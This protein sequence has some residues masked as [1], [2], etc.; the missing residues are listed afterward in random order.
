[1]LELPHGTV[2]LLFSDVEGSTALLSRLGPLYADALDGHRKIMRAAWAA[3]GGSEL[4]TEGD[5]FFVVFTAASHAIAAAVEAQQRL[6]GHSWPEGVGLRVRIGIHTGAPQVHDG[7]YIGMD[8][9]RAARIAAA[10]H[11]GQV[12]VSEVTARLL[13]GADSGLEVE[14]TDLGMH[15]LRDLPQPERLYQVGVAGRQER[16]PP[17]KSLG[18]SSRLPRRPTRL[19]GRAGELRSIRSA[20]DDP[21]ARLLTLTGPGGSGKTRLA[22]EAAQD[23][24]ESFGDGVFFVPLA[25]TADAAAMCA[26]IADVVGAPPDEPR[27][28][29]MLAHVAHRHALLVLD[30]L[31]QIEDAPAVVAEI[32]DTARDVFVLATSR[33][34]L[35]V[36]GEREQPVPPLGLPVSAEAAEASDAVQL[37]VQQAQSVN[38][39]FALVESNVDD[40][41]EVCRRLDGLPLAVELA[42]ARTKLL[43][44]AALRARLGE[45]LDIATRSG[46]APARQRTLRD[47]IRWSYDLLSPTQQSVLRSLAVFACGADPDAV[48]AVSAELVDV[49]DAVD[50]LSD[51]LDASL[52]TVREGVG[53]EPRIEILQTVQSFA[54]DEALAAEELDGLRERHAEYYLNVIQ[55]ASLQLHGDRFSSAR[56]RFELDHDNLQAALDWVLR[57]GTS[58][59]DSSVRDDLRSTIR[60][61]RW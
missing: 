46:Q 48:R 41:V 44:P 37:F 1:M 13:G 21:D 14:L 39:R 51:L 26:T 36:A 55:E 45:A 50:V 52:V 43:T 42:A 47:T 9:H 19:V 38:P 8:V 4:G 16:F 33:S 20:L 34:P 54:L 7:G 10:A 5:S 29:R 22:I 25:S 61:W 58:P 35:H 59:T 23:H 18:A 12:V 31:E 24:A 3:H 27:R 57:P 15:V 53:G 49:G 60:R 56:E 2:T 28:E 6:V 40:V 32:L 11:G 17:L 30:N